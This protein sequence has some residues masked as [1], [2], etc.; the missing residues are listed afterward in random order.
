MV[1]YYLIGRY[2]PVVAVY[3]GSLAVAAA[4]AGLS[5]VRA[6]INQSG[7][8]SIIIFLLGSIIGTSCVILG[9]MG[10]TKIIEDW[11]SG[12]PM[13]FRSFCGGSW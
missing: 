7:R 5:V 6:I 8:A 2:P 1:E 9:S 12:A 3:F 11:L 4:F 13:G 10:G